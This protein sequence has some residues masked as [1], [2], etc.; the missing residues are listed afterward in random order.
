[1]DRRG[2]ITVVAVVVGLGWAFSGGVARAQSTQPSDG[3]GSGITTG[4]PRENVRGGALSARRPG[5]R[6]RDAIGSHIERQNV[7]LPFNSQAEPVSVDE[8][9][10]RPRKTFLLAFIESL[11]DGLVQITRGIGLGAA[12]GSG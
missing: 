2:R 7:S 11:F 12:L 3:D 5:I 6:V 8:L 1:M 10:E 9:P 4:T